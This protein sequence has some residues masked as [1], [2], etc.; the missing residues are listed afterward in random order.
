MKLM[1]PFNRHPIFLLGHQMIGDMDPP[2]Y[3][4]MTFGFDFPFDLGS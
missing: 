2:D 1:N 3:Q 4:D